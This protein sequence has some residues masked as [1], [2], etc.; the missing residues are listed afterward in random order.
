MS[1]MTMWITGICV[2]F[3]AVALLLVGWCGHE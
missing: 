1:T 3:V 2:G